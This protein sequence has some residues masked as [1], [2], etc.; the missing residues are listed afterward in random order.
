MQA[1]PPTA[2]CF[3]KLPS[4]G[5]FVRVHATGRA[6][7]GLDAWLQRG[8]RHAQRS[9]GRAFDAASDGAP[10]V[11]FVFDPPAGPHLLLG[12]L[13]P[14]RDRSGRR[15]PFLVAVEVERAR[16]EGRR[17]PSWP[18]RYQAVFGEAVALVT[19]AVSGAVETDG[20]PHRLQHLRARFDATPFL[21]DY[22][23]R[24]RTEESETLW[25]RTWGDAQDGRKY[26]LLRNLAAALDGRSN[27]HPAPLAFPLPPAGD[28][29]AASAGLAV[30][31]WLEVF[32]R[33]LGRP[34]ERPTYLWRTTPEGPGRLLVSA[35][36][37]PPALFAELVGDGSGGAMHLDDGG[38]ESAVRAALAL[39][40]HLGTLLET[41]GLSLWTFLQHC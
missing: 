34:P 25:A 23:H 22:E 35:T 7:E 28:P 38:G 1:A 36:P 13:K 15:Y 41:P 10:A 37:P 12:A 33:M 9:L 26:I 40:P 39:P 18:L 4:H 27:G 31:F 8:V 5:D 19:D 29:L 6:V 2:T 30:S 14:S 20:L 17:L 21:V 32:W 16:V 3:G 11:S 24:L